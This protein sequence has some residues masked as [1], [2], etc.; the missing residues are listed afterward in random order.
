[1]RLKDSSHASSKIKKSASYQQPMPTKEEVEGKIFNRFTT[2]NDKK[3][4]H[5]YFTSYDFRENEKDMVDFWKDIVDYYYESIFGSFALK[6]STILDYSK[7]KGKNPIGLPNI[8][9]ELK[10]ENFYITDKD[11]NDDYFYQKNF[12]DLYPNN[13]S[14]M[15]YLSS[16]VSK[17]FSYAY[18]YVG[19]ESTDDP[20]KYALS[21]G[22]LYINYSLFTAHCEKLI[23]CLREILTHND[24]EVISKASFKSFILESEIQYGDSYLELALTYLTKTKKIEMFKIQQEAGEIEC[25]KLLRDPKDT[26]TSKDRATIQILL[27]IESLSKRIDELDSI[28]TS[29]RAKAKESLRNKNRNGA[30]QYLNKARLYEK[31]LT[32]YNNVQSTLE[33][34]LFDL[35]S[36]ETNVQIKEILQNSCK[37]TKDIIA[38]PEEFDKVTEELKEHMN[39]QQDVKDMFKEFGNVDDADVDNELNQLMKDNEKEEFDNFISDKKSDKVDLPSVLGKDE[40]KDMNKEKDNLDEILE[41]LQNA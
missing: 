21:S 30:K 9:V 37:A 3:A 32:H 10:Q 26:V 33:Q 4:F 38:S 41:N 25:I 20:S 13:E 17:M 1:M 7:F 6:V 5:N 39:E 16:G 19:P 11:I 24:S 22:D 27:Q 18:S 29:L 36:V 23:S 40:N 12:P 34:T 28:M 8:L 2:L 31:Q 14:W 35:K 15:S